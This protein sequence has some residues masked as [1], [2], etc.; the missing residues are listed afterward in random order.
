MIFSQAPWCWKQ[1]RG[2]GAAELPLLASLGIAQVSVLRKTA[3]RYLL[4]R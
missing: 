1:E 4:H 3:G 2:L